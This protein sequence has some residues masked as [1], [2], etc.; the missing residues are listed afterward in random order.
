MEKIYIFLSG[1]GGGGVMQQRCWAFLVIFLVSGFAVAL[2]QAIPE[3]G[4]VSGNGDMR[5][6]EAVIE[7][8]ENN[9]CL[10]L[11]GE[12]MVEFFATWCS[13]CK[14]LAPAWKR[15]AVASVDLG[16]D[17][18]K[19]DVLT[20]TS[21]SERFFITA[22]PTIYHV[23]DGEFRQY[24]GSREFDALIHFI[25]QKQWSKLEPM[26][27]W[28]K[29]DTLYM[30]ILSYIFE[31]LDTLKELNVF[32]QEVYG[33]PTWAAYAFFAIATIFVGAALGLVLVCVI[34]FFHL[35]EK[36]Q[37]Q[38]FWEAKEKQQNGTEDIANDEIEDEEINENEED[39]EG[40][41]AG[42]EQNDDIEDVSSSDGEKNSPSESEDTDSEKNKT[43]ATKIKDEK[44]SEEKSATT[45]SS[46][47]RKRKPRKAD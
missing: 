40:T 37:R 16:V 41:V 14:N 24:R 28:K 38:S 32:L 45:S 26:S 43:E 25:K 22:L 3:T 17:V 8:T 23:K 21:L 4:T 27:A 15:F 31:F 18:A 13:V 44:S 42:E 46:E 9:W 10:M 29:P 11:K 12:W 6:K 19:I 36:T 47:V 7:L 2:T 33:L 34:D 1:G 30:S 20:S 35:S 5:H 39:E